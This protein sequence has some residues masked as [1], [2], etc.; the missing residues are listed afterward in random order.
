MEYY[1]DCSTDGNP[2]LL[3]LNVEI[4][5]RNLNHGSPLSISVE[6]TAPKGTYSVASLPRMNL[7][8]QMTKIE[9]KDER[10]DALKCYLSRHPDAHEW[11]PDNPDAPHAANWYKFYVESIY[12]LGGS[13]RVS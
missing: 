12:Y 3:L 8:G 10:D 6:T 13:P 7:N 9:S 11:T 2:I 4:T 1:A 5:T